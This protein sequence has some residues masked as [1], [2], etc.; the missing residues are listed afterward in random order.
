M[1]DSYISVD[2]ET[3]GLNPK[4]DKIIEL[5]AVKV[6]NNKIE[7]TYETFINPHRMIDDS[8]IALTGI[9]NEQLK[10]AP[11]IDDKIEEIIGFFEELP[12]LGHHIIFDYSFLKHRTV[13]LGIQF[14]KTGID[15]LA[16]CRIFMPEDSK[17]NLSNACRY[18]GI[19]MNCAHRALPDSIAAHEL[20]Q[21]LVR[22]F[23]Q[24][25]FEEF[26][27]KPLIYKAKKEQRAT[28]RQ[29][30]HLRELIKY[31]RIN[32]SVDIDYLSKNEISRMVDKII[33]QYGRM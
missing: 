31:H 9:T 26:Q 11:L 27:A 13:N 15:T 23:G 10:H 16:L 12:L 21:A 8:I 24:K 4:S 5:G 20:Y 28:K 25:R 3:T 22:E 18:F 17:K 33:S 32:L 6:V 19:S 29:K 14:E 30:D 7:G 1:I 2:L